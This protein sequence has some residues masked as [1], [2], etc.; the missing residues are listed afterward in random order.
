MLASLMAP[1][2]ASYTTYDTYGDVPKSIELEN[3][4]GRIIE[5]KDLYDGKTDSRPD[6]WDEITFYKD[7]IT[8]NGFLK[9]WS[10]LAYDIF[11][12]QSKSYWDHAGKGWD[13]D[14]GKG[15][16]IDL[17]HD[18]QYADSTGGD[19]HMISTGLSVAGSLKDVQSRAAD[20][21][22]GLIGRKLTGAN[23]LSRHSIDALTDTDQT[24][25]YTTVSHVDRYG[26]TPQYGYNSFSIAFYDFQLHV[27][28]DE[29]E[30]KGEVTTNTG[31]T[32]DGLVTLTENYTFDDIVGEATLENSI[33]ETISTSI[34]NSESYSFGQAIGIKA[35]AGKKFRETGLS[36]SIALSG[37]L[38]YEQVMET[39]YSTENSIT[40]ITNKS[41]KVSK[42]VPAH[43]VE[44]GQQTLAE[45][46]VTTAYDCPVGLTYKVAIFSMCGTCYDDNAAVQQFDTAGYEQRSFVT[47]FGESATANDAVESLYQRADNH[48]SDSTYDET[49]G[50]VKG[51][52]HDNKVWCTTLNWTD[53]A[54]YGAP[55]SEHESGL[56]NAQTLIT[57]L[58]KTYPMSTTGAATTVVQDSITTVEDSI[59]PIYPIAEVYIPWQGLEDLNFDRAFHLTVGEEHSILSYRVKARDKDAVDY[60]G[61]VPSTGTWKIV[62]NNGN[63]DKNSEVAE[64]VYDKVT[65]AQTLV[66]KNPGTTYVKYFIPENTYYTYKDEV[67]SNA[68]IKS[69]AY[70]VI[71]TEAPTEAFTGTITVTGTANTIVGETVNL[72][73]E[74]SVSAYDTSGKEVAIPVSWEAQDLEN[75]GI[76][77]S[78]DG[79]MTVTQPGTFH[80]RAYADDV[81][82]DWVEVVAAEATE[83]E[84]IICYHTYT[85]VT[86][87]KWYDKA[88]EFVFQ[89]QI[90]DGIG[91]NLFNPDGQVNRAMA[92]QVLYNAAG[93][94]SIS[95]KTQF[96]D[97]PTDSW[98]AKAV[99]WAAENG[100]ANGRSDTIFAPLDK[101]TR[102]ELVAFLVRYATVS[103]MSL[104]PSDDGPVLVLDTFTDSDQVS[105]WAKETM[106]KALDS[107]LISGRANGTLDPKGTATRAEL[108][109]TLMNL[110][111]ERI[112]AEA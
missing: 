110:L 20:D 69:A 30:V 83:P 34:T 10:S 106:Q 85:D 37:N 35:S 108:A 80:V 11:R 63:E 29:S 88:V 9:D 19:D 112:G 1:A 65:G 28:S 32:K 111:S 84:S 78:P 44:M 98:Y 104:T 31:T 52:N 36:F 93:S 67:S 6:L 71:V 43:T 101:V 41:Y 14:F 79:A 109:Q 60:Y 97:V 7:A 54:N 96:T 23:F 5:F 100:I 68:T 89:N 48:R 94:P 8:N 2:L 55:S 91:N 73:S 74:L 57:D 15:H 72:N 77:V 90:M 18:F 33:T 62:D 53:I 17:V 92:A 3:E 47:L 13:K 81:Y 39:A 99:A 58:G 102:E 107:G 40:D 56:K 82:S 103:N 61:F 25:L 105:A 51:T 45:T 12:S 76:S 86:H 16:Y 21:V 4:N 42:P 66:A 26:K 50:Y 22:A 95:G 49:Y 46:A 64:M 24:V 27:L 70:K 75:K 38:S 87:S 59:Q